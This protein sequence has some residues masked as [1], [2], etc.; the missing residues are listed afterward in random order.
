MDNELKKAIDGLRVRVFELS[1]SEIQ[2]KTVKVS[3]VERS[4]NVTKLKLFLPFEKA[5]HFLNKK[6]L[7]IGVAFTASAFIP[8]INPVIAEGLKYLGFTVSGV[9]GAH[10]IAKAS[11]YGEKGEF[12]SGELVAALQDLWNALIRVYTLIRRK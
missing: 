10:K 8:G 12:G 2:P 6:K 11:K 4:V 7:L 3:G 1:K 9:G 5:W